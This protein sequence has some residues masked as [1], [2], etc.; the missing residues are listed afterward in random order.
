M[1]KIL[2]LSSVPK[3]ADHSLWHNVPATPRQQSL[4]DQ[5][6]AQP[7]KKPPQRQDKVTQR[8]VVL[9]LLR[10]ARAR[11]EPLDLPSIL[12]S[13]IAQY[14]A[15]LNELRSRGFQI[16]NRTERVNGTVRSWYE[17]VHDPERDSEVP[18]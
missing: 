16:E 10:D 2:R 3:R 13:R 6:E 11:G 5:L 7:P 15:R 14:S 1:G 12:N 17:L 18:S 8:D 9:S 4:F